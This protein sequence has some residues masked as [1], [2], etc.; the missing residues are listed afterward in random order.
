MLFENCGRKF[1]LPNCMG[2]HN[3]YRSEIAV[4]ITMP[5]KEKCVGQLERIIKFEILTNVAVDL[6]EV[7]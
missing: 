4:R 3:T 5:P 1:V 7:P 6:K 2:F